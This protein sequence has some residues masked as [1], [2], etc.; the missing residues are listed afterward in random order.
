VHL[1]VGLRLIPAETEI[2]QGTLPGAR[3]RGRPRTQGLDGQHQDVD[4][5]PRGRVSQ[6]DRDQWRKYVDGVA[7]RRIE[8][9]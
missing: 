1:V 4:R 5:T 3:T 6:N 9:G 8:D 2:M 7:N